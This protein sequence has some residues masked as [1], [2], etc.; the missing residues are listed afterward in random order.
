MSRL[1]NRRKFIQA[2]LATAGGLGLPAAR[3]GRG[4]HDSYVEAI[5]IGSGFGGAVAALRL[6]EARIETIVLER[7]K[8]WPITPAGNTFSNKENPDGRTT[9]LS[10]TTILPSPPFQDFPIDVFTGV[11][12]QKKA[13]D[14]GLAAYRGAGVGGGSLVYGGIALQPPKEFF[15]KIFPRTLD[16]DRLNRVY[17]P[18]VRAMLGA[19]PI[20]DDILQTDAF[21]SARLLIAQATK[22]GLTITK[23]DMAFDWHAVRE[24]MAGK[25]VPSVIAGEIYFGTNSGAKN[26]LDRNYLPKAEETRHVEIKPLHLVTSIEESKRGYRVFAN[27]LNERGHVISQKSFE[28][29]YLF[30]AAGS[31]G[32][33]ELLVRARAHR[34]LSNLNDA[35]GQFWGPNGDSVAGIVTP[36]QTNINLGV[37]GV[38]KVNDF[39]NPIAPVALEI[40]SAVP[41]APAGVLFVLGQ[42]ISKPDGY[43]AYNKSTQS[44]DLFWP[45]TSQDT[46]K[47]AA[48]ITK[49]YN[50]LNQANGTSLAGPVDS[51]VS[52]HPL[53]GAVIGAVCDNFGEVFGHRNL[54][55]MDGALIPGSAG[56][57]NPAPT[58]AALAEQS[59]DHFLDH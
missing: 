20:P 26:S 23:P 45:S 49:T 52:A 7:G 5:V 25:R 2:S 12:D 56:C 16:Y 6:G 36:Q 34:T 57:V 18:R 17:Y 24:E 47:N 53:G 59:M 38:V 37:G 14:S 8:R 51:L 22:A 39:D 50:R 42:Q 54:F 40:F 30:L 41:L 4:E 1:L 9:W 19:T 15:H 55:V 32:T 10:N 58:I 33:S 21:L 3:A 13:V 31:I 35:V 29:R 11:L 46:V 27:E 28:C 48:A 43:L 44:V